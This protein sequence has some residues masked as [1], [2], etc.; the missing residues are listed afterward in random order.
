MDVQGRIKAYVGKLNRNC[1][2]QSEYLSLWEK[3]YNGYDANF[4]KY[5]IYQNGE[6]KTFYKKQMNFAK[7]ACEDLAN[8]LANEKCDIIVPKEQ[9]EKLDN[10]LNTNNFWYMLNK[11][12][13]LAAALSLSALVIS[14]KDITVD[15]NGS[16][17]GKTGKIK[18]SGINA[19]NIYPITI[20][21]GEITECA[22]YIK[23]TNY[24]DVVYH[25]QN[26]DGMYEI[27][28][29]RQF[30]GKSSTKGAEITIFKAK[31]TTPW[32]MMI[33]LNLANNLDVDSELPISLFANSIDTLKAIDNKYDAFDTEYTLAKK[34]IFVSSDLTQ[35]VPSTDGSGNVKVVR[36]FDTNDIVFYNLPRSDDGKPLISTSNDE[37]RY[38]AYID[39][40]NEELNI[41]SVK[42]GF[43]KNHYSLGMGGAGEGRIMTATA[44]VSMQSQLFTTIKKHEIV[45]EKALRGFVKTLMQVATMY[46][47][48]EFPEMN[49]N[50]INIKFDDS[51]FEDKE[52]EMA[53]DRTNVAA[54]L[55]SVV[56]F[57][58][59]WYAQSEDDAKKFINENLK[60]SLIEH[61]LPGLAQGGI[62]PSKYVE[63]VF[64]EMNEVEQKEMV[65]YITAYLDSL[66]V[67]SEPD[68]IDDDAYQGDGA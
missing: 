55:M 32:Y 59:K 49:D 36:V 11:Q 48:D 27:H 10:I 4:H 14:V 43:G 53:R 9:K 12:T 26:D 15:A 34:R 46:T 19:K 63:I 33:Q 40:I 29:E 25:L 44:V 3:W 58:Q 57:R 38:Q 5:T 41:A 54:G 2:S 31:T 45:L 68:N 17:R 52:T 13:E 67:S 64:P 65:D 18:I 8:L 24:E 1:E 16:L 30:I 20:D 28:T 62:S 56:E 51:V 60:Y 6:Y 42:M 66:K 37:I 39:G 61:Y 23:S 7:K 47:P 21:N 50:D 22:F 35:V